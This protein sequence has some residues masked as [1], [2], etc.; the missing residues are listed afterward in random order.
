[1]I[2]ISEEPFLN[3]NYFNMDINKNYKVDYSYI[4]SNIGSSF[5]ISN[6]TIEK[7][8]AGIVRANI[9]QHKIEPSMYNLTI[10]STTDH[11]VKDIGDNLI[12]SSVVLEKKEI[13]LAVSK[14]DVSIETLTYCQKYS[15]VEVITELDPVDVVKYIDDSSSSGSA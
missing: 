9:E 3:A 1:M 10:S 8:N 15:D 4:N 12:E 11:A 5:S 6:I 14:A 7:E 13:D 2:R